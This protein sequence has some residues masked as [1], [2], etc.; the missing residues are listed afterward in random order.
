[1]MLTAKP[2]DS[3]VC[4]KMPQIT[5]GKPPARVCVTGQ[6]SYLPEL[7]QGVHFG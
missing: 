6:K 1:M 5:A 3:Q 4:G 2:C 7:A